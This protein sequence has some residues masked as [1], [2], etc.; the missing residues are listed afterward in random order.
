MYGRKIE[1]MTWFAQYFS[2]K[3]CKL[4]AVKNSGM[5][6]SKEALLPVIFICRKLAKKSS[7]GGGDNWRNLKTNSEISPD[8]VGKANQS[9]D[10]A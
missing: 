8:S 10:T 1:N 6:E 2:L 5:V 7:N 9:Y 3:V 4:L